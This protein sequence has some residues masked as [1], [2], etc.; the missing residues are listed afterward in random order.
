MVEAAPTT[1]QEESTTL[2][3]NHPAF[4]EFLEILII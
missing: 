2:V 4:N 3:Q 1:A